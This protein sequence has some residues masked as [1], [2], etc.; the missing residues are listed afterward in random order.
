MSV[1][2]NLKKF[3]KGNN[4]NDYAMWFLGYLYKYWM[5]TRGVSRQQIYKILPFERYMASFEFYHTQGWDY[6][7]EDAIKTYKD[8]TYII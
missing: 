3:K 1:L 2:D 5:K 8:K 4:V 7:I 6:V